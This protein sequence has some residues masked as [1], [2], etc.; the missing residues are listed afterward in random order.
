ML[1]KK[2]EN[3]IQNQ[4]AANRKS[5]VGE[6]YN[7]GER[8]RKES[9][10]DSLPASWANLHRDGY[11]HI[12]D[13]DAY[14]LTT[15][16]LALDIKNAFPYEKFSGLGKTMIIVRV[17]DFIKEVFAKLGNEQAGG[18]AFANFDMEFSEIFTRLGVDFRGNEEIFS[19]CIRSLVLWCNEMHTRMGQ[20][21]Y[22]VTFNVGLGTDYFSR[23]LTRT[24]IS[25]FENA[26]ELVFKP[27]IVFK[28]KAGVNQNPSDP[29]FDLYEKALNCTAKKMIPTYLLCDCEEEKNVAPEKLSVM[30]CRSRVVDDVFGKNGSVGRGNV[31]N[32]S[33]NLPRLALEV[34]KDFAD[35]IDSVKLEKLKSRWLEIALPVTDILLDRY[36]KTLAADPTLFPTNHEYKLWCED[37]KTLGVAETFKHGTL[38]IGFIGLSEAIFILTG[39]KYWEDEETYKV[40]LDLVAFMRNYTDSLIKKHNLN[41]SLLATSGELISGRFVESD[42]LK[43]SHPALE[44]G[45]YTNS[46]HVEVDSGLSATEKLRY[47]GAFHK[48][49]NG[50]SISYIELG[51]APLGNAEGLAELTEIAVKSGVRYLGFNFPKDVCDDCG[52]SGIFDE[53]PSCKSKNITR[54][55]RVSGYLEILDGFTSGKKAEAMAREANK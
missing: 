33:I 26:G 45:F 35:E 37:M 23:F 27:N 48:Y 6:N 38:S 40:A 53:C 22:Y 52:T 43:F 30:G 3:T 2:S 42:K 15:N 21:S 24:L 44:K 20:T 13:L 29:N 11:I 10:L 51:E 34:S 9:V 5:Y 49:A 41:F 17:F 19:A 55:R 54:I 32:I 18:M 31:A 12:H 39:K 28:V 14:G 25:E 8:A 47:E 36:K 4:N 46:F 50:G 7:L 16:C 1:P